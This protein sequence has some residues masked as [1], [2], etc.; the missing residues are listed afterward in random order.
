MTGKKITCLACGVFR[1][2]M[3]ALTAQGRLDCDIITL[4]SMLHM[5]PARLEQ[6]MERTMAFGPNNKFLLVYGDCHPRMH[7]M[8]K[9]E[10]TTKVAGINC[11]DIVLGRDIYRKLQKEQAFIFMPEWTLRWRD[12]FAHE[13]G[14]KKPEVL[15]S[16]IQEHR[17]KLVYVDTG[18]MPVPENMLQDISEFFAMPVAVLTVSL[19]NLLQGM[20]N[21]FQKFMRR[22]SDDK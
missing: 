7:E 22:D 19:E 9:R 15:Q 18:V 13:L 5:K 17:K 1:M 3:E 10:N 20:N 4:E 6:E 11:C 8:Q 2:E 14:F 12:V 21:A 16:F